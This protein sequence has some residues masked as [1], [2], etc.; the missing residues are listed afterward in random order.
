MRYVLCGSLPASDT[1]VIEAQSLAGKLPHGLV[2]RGLLSYF[3]D[4]ELPERLIKTTALQ[5]GMSYVGACLQA[6]QQ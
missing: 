2:R 3:A 6:I 1:A 5:C 4:F